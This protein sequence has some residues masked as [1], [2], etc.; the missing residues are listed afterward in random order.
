MKRILG[1]DPGIGNTGW[2]IVYRTATGYRLVDSGYRETPTKSTFGD[3]LDSHFCTITDRLMAH[4]PDALAIESAFF[5]KNISSHNSTV[6]VIAIAELAAYRL[7]IPTVQIK[8][9]LVKQAVGCGPKASK[10]AVKKRINALLKADIKNHHESD[11]AA[12]AIAALLRGKH[13][14]NLLEVN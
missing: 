12:A 14:S 13:P 8:P 4:T 6:S 1:I 7:G 9:Q 10:D 2:A 3:R 11:A 5:N